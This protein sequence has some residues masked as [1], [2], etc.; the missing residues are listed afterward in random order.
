MLWRN[1]G[2]EYLLLLAEAAGTF[3]GLVS[4]NDGGFIIFVIPLVSNVVVINRQL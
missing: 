1:N 2:G 3:L 4:R